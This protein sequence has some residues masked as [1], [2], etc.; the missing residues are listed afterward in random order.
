M[1]ELAD[2][3]SATPGHKIPIKES[4]EGRHGKTYHEVKA[5][6]K[7]PLSIHDAFQVALELLEI[8]F[9]N[10]E[11]HQNEN[12]SKRVREQL[13]NQT[14]AVSVLGRHGVGK[15]TLLDSL[16]NERMLPTHR[17]NNTA[18]M[19]TIQHTPTLENGP[20]LLD[21]DKNVVA[22]GKEDIVQFITAE[23]DAVRANQKNMSRFVSAN[24]LPDSTEQG[25]RR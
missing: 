14:V 1:T 19:I 9:E 7:E 24:E 5:S 2:G 22:A 16:L 18:V 6:Y 4:F 10:K 11:L 21:A 23:N 15:S 12:K 25:G 13:Q 17:K 8:L 20:R 3:A